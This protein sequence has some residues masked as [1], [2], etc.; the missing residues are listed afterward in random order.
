MHPV[1]AAFHPLVRWAFYVFMFSLPFEWPN[2]S[3]P[4]EVTTLTGMVF[5][6]ATLIQPRACFARLPTALWWFGA[7]L[8]MYW[9]SFVV[10]GAAYPNDAVKAFA[11]RVSLVLVFWAAYNLMRDER[12]AT[13]ALLTFGLACLALAVLSVGGA[14]HLDEEWVKKSGRVTLFGQNPNRAGLILAL[15]ALALVGL[16]YG[17]DRKLLRPRLLVWPLLAVIGIAIVNTGSRGSLLALVLGLWMF[18]VGG[19]SLLVKIRSAV[20]A[21]L[22]IAFLA[23]VAWQLPIMRKRFQQA[24]HGNLAG[25]E[26]IFPAAWGL[27]RERP[28]LG[29]GPSQNKYELAKRLPEEF[30]TWRDTHNLVLELL[31]STGVLGTIP[32][33][34]G[35]GL[36][37]WGAWTARRGTHG[38]LPFAMSTALLMGNMSGNGIALKLLWIVLA[39]GAATSSL[40]APQRAPPPRQPRTGAPPPPVGRTS[41]PC[42]AKASDL[43]AVGI[44]ARVR[45]P[46]V[47]T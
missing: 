30:R 5:L 23:G 22:I 38:M 34:A 32:F 25:R 16:T 26:K 39:Y 4:V 9:V 24:Q 31:T 17:R 40:L 19:R 11:L 41:R 36:C 13:R 21:V 15:G 33:L 29:W 1:G 14:V 45:R 47:S 7:A 44:S 12:I 10:A 3:I 35:M 18:A 37:V 6:L 28:L 20:V 46:P 43:W 2:R 42:N 8:Y 27:F